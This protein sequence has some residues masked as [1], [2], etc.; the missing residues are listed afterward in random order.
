M[1]NVEQVK[2]GMDKFEERFAQEISIESGDILLDVLNKGNA[3]E[4]GSFDFTNKVDWLLFLQKRLAGH[5]YQ[6]AA[7]GLKNE[8]SLA[9]VEIDLSFQHA[10]VGL[11]RLCIVDAFRLDWSKIITSSGL[12]LLKRDAKS[13]GHH[14]E[15]LDQYIQNEVKEKFQKIINDFFKDEEL[16][17]NIQNSAFRQVTSVL[18]SNKGYPQNLKNFNFEQTQQLI[19]SEFIALALGHCLNR[20]NEELQHQ[21]AQLFEKQGVNQN[22]AQKLATSTRMIHNPVKENQNFAGVHADRLY[23]MFSDYVQPVEMPTF[24]QHILVPV[25]A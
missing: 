3:Y 8:N 7:L 5:T 14:N 20:L 15:K 19:C 10:S 23:D 6:H 12:A 22:Q 11:G 21:I 4:G 1:R 25:K 16:F 13:A 9:M 2:N 18:R 24:L 17:K